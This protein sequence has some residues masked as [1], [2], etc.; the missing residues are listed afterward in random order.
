VKKLLF[1][2]S[3]LSQELEKVMNKLRELD[4]KWHSSQT[5]LEKLRSKNA[6]LETEKKS[7]ENKVRNRYSHAL[8]LAIS[9]LP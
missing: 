8:A 5:E 9:Y 6:M 7:A 2:H 4:E 3:F 1:V